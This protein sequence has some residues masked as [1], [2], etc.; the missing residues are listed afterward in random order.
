MLLYTDTADE[1]A[2]SKFAL[3]TCSSTTAATGTTTSLPAR[4]KARQWLACDE[5]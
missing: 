4:D 1:L 3:S 5:A 2:S